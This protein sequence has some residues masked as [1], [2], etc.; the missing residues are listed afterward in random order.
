MVKRRRDASQRTPPTDERASASHAPGDAA[1]PALDANLLSPELQAQLG[2]GAY[3]TAEGSGLALPGRKHK[4]VRAEAAPA[5]PTLTRKE[6]RAAKGVTRKLAGLQ[7]RPCAGEG[8]VHGPPC[9]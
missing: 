7:V 3:G 6:K 1:E 4:R 9:P 8:R 2:I 5:A